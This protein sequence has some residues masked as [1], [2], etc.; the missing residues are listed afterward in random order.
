[1][2]ILTV[3]NDAALDAFVA[4]Y[5]LGSRLRSGGIEAGT[6][7]TSYSL[8]LESGPFFLRIYEE[9]DFAGAAAEA[10]LLEHLAERGVE[11][12]APLVARDGARIRELAGKPAALF[13]WVAGEMLCQRAVDASA[14]RAVGAALARIHV[15]GPPAGEVLGG[16]RFGPADL[17]LRCDRIASCA[18]VIARSQVDAFRKAVEVAA[19]SRQLA[20]PVGLVHGDLFRDNV[21]WDAG[22]L[23][24]LLDFESAHFGP[25]AYD[26]AVTVLAW[27]FRDCFDFDVGRAIISGYREVR[28]IEPIEID[29]L[30]SEAIFAT[31]RFSITRIT[32]DAIRVG[33]KWQRFAAR[34]AALE[35]LGRSGLREALDL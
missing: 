28:E 8:E 23:R 13:P 1:M 14:A 32:D 26:I 21:L 17:L 12:P 10:R 19:A 4:S 5:G 6:V 3:P 2:A 25:F 27:S 7:N 31:L 15:A 11:T 33:K 29:A 18:D 34:R 30:Y 24:A 16:G 20:L 35:A 22:S 9:Q